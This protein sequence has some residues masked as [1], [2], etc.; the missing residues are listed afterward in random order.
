MGGTSPHDAGA[1]AAVAAPASRAPGPDLGGPI[2]RTWAAV[3]GLLGF[4][5][6]LVAATVVP[7]VAI[8][9]AHAAGGLPAPLFVATLFFG[10]PHVMATLG[11]YAD[12]E[13]RAVVRA[14]PRR[15]VVLPLAA[16][17]AGAA[18]FAPTGGRVGLVLITVFLLWQ[19]QHYT[20]Q[21][22]GVFA[23]WCRAR[24]LGSMVDAERSLIVATT[25]IGALG[26]LRAMALVPSWDGGLRVA[27]ATLIAAGTGAALVVGRDERRL[28][29]V[30]AVWF[31][32]PLHL[33]RLD[34][35]DAAFAY[36]AAHG[37]QYLLLVGHTLRHQRSA[38]RLS[39]VAVL[40]GGAIPLAI[41]TPAMFASHQWLFGIGKGLAAAHF[42]ADAYL[43]RLRNPRI[44]AVLRQRFAF[45]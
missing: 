8:L 13:L 19:T 10:P 17:A 36:Q 12:P 31:Y 1:I 35:L 5:Q 14:D 4:D 43:W 7:F 39:V 44:R 9:L 40:V 45:L 26:I 11:L 16:L 18:A 23:F 34:L 21:N 38:A 29:L 3:T 33:F 27:G 32:A 20:K 6:W 2:G 25:A 28:A 15:F 41:L 24:G 30:A 22:V 42:T 37:A